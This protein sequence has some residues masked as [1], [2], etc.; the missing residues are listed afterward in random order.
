MVS[1]NKLGSGIGGNSFNKN[2]F[3]TLVYGDSRLLGSK[4]IPCPFWYYLITRDR[5]WTDLQRGP[6]RGVNLGGV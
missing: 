6:G 3:L 4:L 5:Q 1:D 2:T